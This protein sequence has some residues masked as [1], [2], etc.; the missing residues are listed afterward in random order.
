MS[1]DA[2]HEAIALPI[3]EREPLSP[4][5]PHRWRCLCGGG[6]LDSYGDTCSYCDGLGFC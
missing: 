5:T 2:G 6:G 4:A 3:C 1:S